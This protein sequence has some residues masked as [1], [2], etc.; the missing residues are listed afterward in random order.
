MLGPELLHRGW[1]PAELGLLELMPKKVVVLV[2]LGEVAGLPRVALGLRKKLL[3]LSQHNAMER[4]RL[5][6]S[7]A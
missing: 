5:S 3:L 1:S 7:M 6:E 4:E 2:G